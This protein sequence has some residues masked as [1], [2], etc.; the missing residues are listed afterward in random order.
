MTFPSNC[1]I[2]QSGKSERKMQTSS[3]QAPSLRT[4]KYVQI[5]ERQKA[6]LSSNCRIVAKS[7]AIEE[8][9]STCV[10]KMQWLCYGNEGKWTII[11][12][13]FSGRLEK[14]NDD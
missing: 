1:I 13:L 8:E 4:L 5:K 2:A 7:K 3:T 12:D 9:S 14:N 6:K 11:I 10:W